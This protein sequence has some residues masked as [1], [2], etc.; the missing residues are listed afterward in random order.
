[1]QNKAHVLWHNCMAKGQPLT[2]QTIHRDTYFVWVWNKL[3][4]GLHLLIDPVSPTLKLKCTCVEQ[5]SIADKMK[6]NTYLTNQN[7]D[8]NLKD[9]FETHTSLDCFEHRCIQNKRLRPTR[10]ERLWT[11]AALVLLAVLVR[12]SG[13][14]FKSA[15]SSSPSWKASVITLELQLYLGRRWFA[16]RTA[17]S[18][19]SQFLH[20]W[21]LTGFFPRTIIPVTNWSRKN[22]SHRTLQ[23]C[24]ESN[25]H[26][27]GPTKLCRENCT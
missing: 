24:V 7:N 27:T 9:K 3:L 6:G 2:T 10:S 18:S 11:S 5:L 25:H 21:F 14:F 16:C 19:S 26:K 8:C 12:P 20:A 15:D 17:K 4:Q 23:T 13:R 1:M 22:G